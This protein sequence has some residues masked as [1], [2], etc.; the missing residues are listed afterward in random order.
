VPRLYNEDEQEKSVSQRL[1]SAVSSSELQ[2]SSPLLAMTSDN[3]ICVNQV[4]MADF[5]KHS[6]PLGSLTARNI[7]TC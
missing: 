4:T 3:R 7:L 6:E 1:E 2:V 5:Y